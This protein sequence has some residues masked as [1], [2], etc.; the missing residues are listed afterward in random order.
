MGVL[1][2]G[3]AVHQEEREFAAFFPG[4]EAPLGLDTTFG[5][6]SKPQSFDEPEGECRKSA[7]SAVKPRFDLVPW[8]AIEEIAQVLTFGAAKYSDNNWARG[9]RWGR[10]FAALCR[11]IFAWWRGEDK[12]PETGYSHLAHAGCCLVF[13]M[14]YQRNGWGTDDRFRGPDQKV[15]RK[16]DG[17]VTLSVEDYA[18]QLRDAGLLRDDQRRVG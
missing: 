14:S 12:D 11:H 9:A 17:A 8:P 18:R 16:N 10:Y 5:H 13:L 4:A 2:T 1:V 15:F 7:E 6:L 3:F